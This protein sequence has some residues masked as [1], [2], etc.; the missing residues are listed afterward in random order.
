MPMN[1][2]KPVRK[3][4]ADGGGTLRRLLGHAER[5]QRASQVLH[6]HLNAPLAQHCQV[7]N[8]KD[9]VVVVHADSPAWAAKLRFH[10]AGMLGQFNKV[11]SFGTVRAI[12]IKVSPLSEVRSPV[13]AERLTLSEHAAVMIKS[14]ADATPHPELKEVL[15]RLAQRR[16][17]DTRYKRKEKS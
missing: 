6:A 5:L 4:L 8:I 10:V 12:R 16:I 17:Q 3:L 9:G 1:S 2:L 13:L 14:A 11:Q 15:L 7:A